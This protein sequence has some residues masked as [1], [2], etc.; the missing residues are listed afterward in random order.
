M[1]AKFWRQAKQLEKSC[2]K[3]IRTKTREKNVADID[4]RCTLFPCLGKISESILL[5]NYFKNQQMVLVIELCNNNKETKKII[6][7]I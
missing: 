6:D 7:V 5:P 1:R 2:W 4:T 3:D